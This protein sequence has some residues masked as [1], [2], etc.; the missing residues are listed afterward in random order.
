MHRVRTAN[1]LSRLQRELGR[2][3][4]TL[5]Y[6][7]LA[8]PICPV[9]QY[10][11]KGIEAKIALQSWVSGRKQVCKPACEIVYSRRPANRNPGSA[12]SLEPPIGGGA[13][14]LLVV[15]TIRLQP[16]HRRL[17]H[18]LSL[19][20][21]SQTHFLRKNLVSALSPVISSSN[22]LSRSRRSDGWLHRI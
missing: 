5:I 6:T 12:S 18:Y 4:G 10:Y 22:C 21:I 15:Q 1:E 7:H 16:R 2:S 9:R 19:R 11:L 3:F 20:E 13:F 17:D 8:G 14:L